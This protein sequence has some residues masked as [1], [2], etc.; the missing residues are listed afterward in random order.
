MLPL[1]ELQLA[2]EIRKEERAR[3]AK[4]SAERA[5]ELLPQREQ[6][7]R[8]IVEKTFDGYVDHMA[9]GR[10]ATYEKSFYSPD[11]D[12]ITLCLG[13]DYVDLLAREFRRHKYYTPNV[14]TGVSG[15]RQ[16]GEATTLTIQM[17]T[18]QPKQCCIVC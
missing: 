5:L 4:E 17:Y 11:P 9:A 10:H 7:A 1:T 12:I 14:K 2:V 15:R 6:I 16:T 8:E 13:D 3:D 18:P